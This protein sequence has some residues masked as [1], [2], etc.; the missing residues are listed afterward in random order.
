MQEISK[1]KSSQNKS[2]GNTCS[3]TGLH[4]AEPQLSPVRT[5]FEKA[6]GEH[7]CFAQI[8]LLIHSITQVVQNIDFICRRHFSLIQLLQ[9]LLH[10]ELSVVVIGLRVCNLSQLKAIFSC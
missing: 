10:P 5:Q 4:L 9:S 3:T 2:L 6:L 7:H 8:P 1:T